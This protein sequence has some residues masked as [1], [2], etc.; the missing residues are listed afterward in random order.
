MA[1]FLWNYDIN[2]VFTKK[3][4]KHPYDNNFESFHYII[5]GYFL[6]KIDVRHI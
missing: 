2:T 1:A 6:K 3:K 4:L 5:D